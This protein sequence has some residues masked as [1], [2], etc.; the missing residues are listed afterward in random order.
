MVGYIKNTWGGSNLGLTKKTR[1]YQAST[2]ELYGG[3]AENKMQQQV[4]WRALLST[5]S[6]YGAAK[7][8]GFG[9]LKL[10]WAY[11]MFAL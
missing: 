8:Y 6:P 4:L 9:L 1:V 5:R 3:L 2:S 10:P 7:I 11:N